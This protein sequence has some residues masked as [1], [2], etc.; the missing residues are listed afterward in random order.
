MKLRLHISALLLS[1]SITMAYGNGNYTLINDA[2]VYSGCNC[3]QLTSASDNQGGG[4]YQNNAIN[5]NNSFDYTFSVFLGCNTSNGADGIVFVLTNNITGIGAS[6]GGLGYSGLPGNSVGIEFDTYQNSWDPPYNHI[7]IEVGG[8]VQHPSGTI[9]GPVA[10]IPSSG[11]IDDCNWHTVRIVWDVPTQTYSVYFDGNLR[12]SYTGNIVAQYFGGNPIVNWGWS[13]ST[14]ADN[15]YQRFCVNSTSNWI[16]GVDY[17]TC[18]PVVQFHDI[19]TSSVGTVQSWAWNFGD[20]ASGALNY[21]TLENPTHT[22]SG[23]GTYMVSLIITDTT[24]CADTFSHSLVVNPPISLTDTLHEPLCNGA[25]NGSIDLGATG[26]F[27]PSAGLGGYS[28]TWS[29]GGLGPDII[30]ISAGTYNVTVSDGICSSTASYTLN[31][32]APLT[33]VVSSVNPNCGS[34]NGSVTIN[35]I[36][37]G[38]PPYSNVS[39]DGFPGYTLSGLGPGTYVANFQDANGCSSLL[40]Y[41]ETLINQPCGYTVS[42]SSSNVSC[43]NGSNG[44]VTLTVTG[45]AGP[46][47]IDWYNS[48]S[49]LVGTT[50]TVGGLPAGT[51]TYHYTDGVPTTFTGTVTITQPGGPL[52]ISITTVNPSCS[53]LTNGSA[54]ASIVANGSPSYSYAWSA[55]G[56]PNA[57]TATGLSPGPISVTVT[58]GNGCTAV[59]SGTLNNQSALNPSVITTP[60]SCHGNTNGTAIAVVTG[61][62]PGYTY[63]WS[64]AAIGDTN[65]NIAANTYTVTVTD[66]N[67]CTAT[68]HGT[69][70]Q[71]NILTDSISFVNV[72]CFGG[73]SGSATSIPTGG[74]GGNSYNW[75]SSATSATATGLYSGSYYYVTVT[76]SKL[77]RVV[78]S[79]ELSQP[80]QL[81]PSIVSYDS[82]TCFGGHNGGV[83]VTATGG[84]PS[85]TYALDGSGTYQASGIFTGLSA[86]AHTVTVKDS[87][88]CDSTLSFTIHQPSA[89]VPVII[90]TVPAACFGSCSGGVKL[91][92]TGGVGPYSY[93]IDGLTY[94]SIDSFTGLCAGPYTLYVKD[95]NSCIATLADTI[96]QPSLF[97]LSVVSITEPSCFGGSDGQITVNGSGGTPIYLYDINLGAPTPTG[98][99]SGLSSG[100]YIL[101]G[102]DSHICLDSLHLILGQPALLAADTLS[103]VG[104]SCYGAH[105][106]EISLTVSGGTYPYTYVWTG[107]PFI[108]DSL[109]TGLDT[110]TYTAYI[111]DA[112]GC[113]DSVT[114]SISQPSPLQLSVVSTDS[115]NC[116]GGNDGGVT[117]SASG[118]S[119]AYQYALDGSSSYQSGSTFSGLSGGTHTITVKDAHNCDTTISFQIYEPA[120]LQPSA[121]YKRNVS[122]NGLCNGVIALSASGGT[123][124]YSYSNNGGISY[125]P[126]DSFT[127]LCAGAYSFQVRDAHNCTTVFLDTVIQP[128][129]LSMTP[130]TITTPYCYGSA[131]G[132]IVVNVIGGTLP[133]QYDIN[134]GLPQSTD[135]F[136][137]LVAGNYILGVAD[138]N[139]CLDSIHISLTQPN[140]LVA[141]TLSTTAVS[142]FGGSNGSV[143]LLVSGGSYPYHYSWSVAGLTDSFATGLA[144]GTYTAF[145][146]DLRGCADTVVTTISQPTQLL[147]AIVSTDSVSCFGNSDGSVLVTASNGSAP[148]TYALDGSTA[149][150]SSGSFTGLAAGS[151]TVTVK[152]NH[153]CD[154]TISFTIFQ[155]ALLRLSLAQTRNI[156]C[157][158]ACDGSIGLSASGGT[159]PYSYSKDGINF[160]NIDSFNNLCAGPYVLLV[161]DAHNCTANVYDSLTQPQPLTLSLTSAVMPSC[162]GR[163][164]G[165]LVVSAAGGTA[166][167]Q[168]SIDGGALQATGNFNNLAAGTHVL[169]VTDANHCIDTIHI[170]LNQPAALQAYVVTSQQPNCHGQSDGTITLGVT[171]GNYPYSYQ[172]AGLPGITDSLGTGL[173]AGAYIISVT[174]A[175]GCDTTINFTLSQPN[176]II[177]QQTSLQNA[178]C[179]GLSNGSVTYTASGGTAP[180]SFSLDGS[181]AQSSGLFNSLPAGTH[182]I[183]VKDANGCDTMVSFIIREPQVLI[184]HLD[185][186]FNI[187]SCDGSC[188]GVIEGSALGGVPPY[189]FSIDGSTY[190]S[191]DSFVQ[192][193]AGT[194]N[195]SVK[196]SNG[197][198]S[199]S[200]TQATIPP[201]PA[202]GVL[203]ITPGDIS[204]LQDSVLQLSTAFSY[205]ASAITGYSWSPVTG[206][207]CTNC[208]N[209]SVNLQYAQDSVMIYTAA[210]SYNSGCVA[211]AYDTIH[212]IIGAAIADAF[213]PNGDQLNERFTIKASGVSAFKMTIYNRWGE[214]MYESEDISTGWDGTCK[215][216]AQ[217]IG[218]YTF[219]LAITYLNGQQLNKV[220]TVSLLR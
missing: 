194:Y 21:S 141:D 135:T 14:G 72:A 69:V 196:D 103:T 160:S 143:T 174:D 49:V 32:P 156:S 122:C 204:V 166:T 214:L 203:T 211:T 79:V 186:T 139:L 54:V 147:P 142:C 46:V 83:T 216:V 213:T 109:A 117:V 3:Y 78:D 199:S 65:F 191:S 22:Y 34:N 84:S 121:L 118:G 137:G 64:N 159:Q 193:C 4:V 217:P 148:Y 212:I 82:V 140:A 157:N 2:V 27:G 92:A 35:S 40:T 124:P 36:S 113:R 136:S 74:N 219:F 171:G 13:G 1:L 25:Y 207:S 182:T 144:A 47:T 45:G 205:P 90:Y 131:N 149:F 95:S 70:S 175:L 145:V 128:A 89:I 162:H 112:H 100:I 18:N 218:D 167:Y 129:A 116:H 20:P 127:A 44:S 10:A 210:V 41:R 55:A 12:T 178:S 39:W 29:T 88:N 53:Y 93:S 99:F 165:E 85:Y 58:D 153:T 119:P 180:L 152:D 19:S 98:T 106:G 134:F 168:Y 42:T 48:S 104:V 169:A 154:S 201:P 202:P 163:T 181:V 76:D 189:M 11:N 170:L 123:P 195:I 31:Q 86:G 61:G 87:H 208:P 17:E 146:T 16:A 190:E 215:G 185:T 107:A 60:D 15:N 68:A 187:L 115:V 50:A 80:S 62:N 206:L 63:V 30:G 43:Y 177:P 173:A 184:A 179:S 138:A 130:G 155:P 108:S 5:L 101:G 220:G 132:S 81:L 198:I 183:T 73:S 52:T 67:S 57:A 75:S 33:A 197:C 97:R 111:T 192:V 188:G 172:W 38:T 56:E 133:Y 28:Y 51:Y 66:R 37:G 151:H 24:G 77:C 94:S 125:T 26:G 9:A 59:A 91:T 120:L 23:P 209:P 110:G 8:Q 200:L 71:P 176:Q 105:N 161:K 7:A 102:G 150:Q 96:T 114:A 6:G 164:N 158:G 126:I